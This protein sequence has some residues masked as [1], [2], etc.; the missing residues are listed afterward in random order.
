MAAAS[1]G[2]T[3]VELLVGMVVAS[4]VATV[5]VTGLSSL[6]R[7]HA[8]GVAARRDEDTAWLV[9][10]AVARDADC[11]DVASCRT[12]WLL[13]GALKHRDAQAQPYADGIASIDF[14]RDDRS[15]RLLTICLVLHDGR[16]Y[17]RAVAR[18]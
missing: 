1:R 6:G 10:A 17:E 15:P 9:L 13:D 8:R 18:P 3:L 14:V 11:V 4:L 16:R 5:V 12:H 2:M 7:G